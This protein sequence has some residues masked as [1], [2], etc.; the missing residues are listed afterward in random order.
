ML[1]LCRLRGRFDLIHVLF[2]TMLETDCRAAIRV[3]E[4]DHGKGADPD[5]RT[6]GQHQLPRQGRMRGDAP[7]R[8][9]REC[10]NIV[11]LLRL[12]MPFLDV[13]R[14]LNKLHRNS[15]HYK[16]KTLRGDQK[17]MFKLTLPDVDDMYRALVLHPSVVRVVALSGGYSRAE[18][19]AKLAKQHGIIA[20]FSRGE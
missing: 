8:N 15:S 4:E 12:N 6:R 18:A 7:R 13:P 5:P 11:T 3:R 17:L 16:L 1:M 2:H 20:S 9:H 14:Y 19:V 10:E